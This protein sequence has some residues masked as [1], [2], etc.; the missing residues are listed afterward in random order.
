M[1]A[2]RAVAHAGAAMLIEC[3]AQ[4]MVKRHGLRTASWMLCSTRLSRWTSSLPLPASS[5]CQCCR[6]TRLPAPCRLGSALLYCELKAA[7]VSHLAAARRHG[8]T[9]RHLRTLLRFKLVHHDA[10]QYDGY[11]L[12]YMGYDFLA[13]RTLLARGHIAAVGRRIGVGKESDVFEVG[14]RG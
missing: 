11:R 2:D 10:K 7:T 4:N 3:V 6:R 8:G 14:T 12:T 5:E 9:Y 13:I 1:L